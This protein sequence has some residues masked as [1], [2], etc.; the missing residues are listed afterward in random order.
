M[1]MAFLRETY[2][3]DKYTVDRHK[4]VD[5]LEGRTCDDRECIKAKHRW[6]SV[7]EIQGDHSEEVHSASS[8]AEAKAWAKDKYG[9]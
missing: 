6:W 7:M 2:R 8:A 9:V 1:Q 3:T 4:C 5:K